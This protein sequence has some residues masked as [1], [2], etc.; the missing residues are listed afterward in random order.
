[1]NPLTW[2]K[3][4]VKSSKNCKMY[5][6]LSTFCNHNSTKNVL[7]WQPSKPPVKQSSKD[8]NQALHFQRLG[9][10]WQLFG[11]IMFMTG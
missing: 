3:L 2:A 9:P 11:L 6:T 10:T 4:N 5:K 8:N 7:V 1:M